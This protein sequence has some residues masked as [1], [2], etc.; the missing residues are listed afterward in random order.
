MATTVKF[1]NK[2]K[3]QILKSCEKLSIQA[4]AGETYEVLPEHS[5]SKG[6]IKKRVRGND[7]IIENTEEKSTVELLNY[8]NNCTN[9]G[10][11]VI[12]DSSETGLA[13][14]SSGLSWG[15]IGLIAL[16]V[17]AAGAAAAGGGG[18]GGGGSTSSTSVADTTA[19][20]IAVRVNTS[21]LAANGTATVTF[22][23][24]EASN[25]FTLADVTAT[26]GVL[27]NFSG[28][29]TAYTA[30]FTANSGVSAA[31]VSVASGTFSDAAGNVNTDGADANNTVTFTVASVDTT[32]PSV[33]VVAGNTNL[34]VGSTV[35]LTFTLSEASTNFTASDVNVVGGV[36]S[37]FSGSGTHYTATFTPTTGVSS[38]SVSVLSGVFSDAIGNVNNDGADANNTVSFTV[39]SA[40]APQITNT[41]IDF[42]QLETQVNATNV[43]FQA[44]GTNVASWALEGSDAGLFSVDPSGNVRFNGTANFEAPSDL[45]KD[46]VYHLTLKAID[47]TGT[48]AD[49]QDFTIHLADVSEI[50]T[51]LNNAAYGTS[52]VGVQSL[53]NADGEASSWNANG[54][55]SAIAN[56][57]ISLTYSFQGVG[58]LFEDDFGGLSAID[59][60]F[61]SAGK[62]FIRTVFANF[63]SVANIAY[64]ENS[65]QV[66]YGAD[67]R[68]FAGTYA[69]LNSDANTL[70][71]AYQPFGPTVT[72]SDYEGNFFF[73]T[74]SSGVNGLINT[75]FSTPYGDEKNT[76][77]H[78]LGHA[79]GLDHPF[80]D[81]N[82]GAGF[83]DY[84][85]TTDTYTNHSGAVTGGGHDTPLTDTTLETIMT[86]HNPDH[87]PASNVSSGIY[88]QTNTP[89]QLGIYDI[90]A[91]QNLYGVNYTTNAGDTQ[92]TFN[93]NT[94]SYLT[95]WDGGG[96]D[97]ITHI[98]DNSALINLNEGTRSHVGTTPGWMLHDTGWTRTITA[99]N[100]TTQS[101]GTATIDA[102]G[103]G[104]VFTANMAAGGYNGTYELTLTFSDNSTQVVNYGVIADAVTQ[105]SQYNL[106][107]AFGVTVENAVGG[108]GDDTIIGNIASNHIT[109]GAGN[110]TMTGGAAG[111]WFLFDDI[112][113]TDTITDFTHGQDVL[114]FSSAMAGAISFSAGVLTV[115]GFGS[116]NLTGIT[117]MVVGT[118]YVF[119]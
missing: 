24:S 10:C 9:S 88:T 84:Y 1:K 61:T 55:S 41:V 63:S 108:N 87:G 30:I 33:A 34:G 89:W 49:T 12:I 3:T 103:H 35:T 77:S 99:V 37:N 101:N 5:K 38:A 8:V 18:G 114:Q 94:P 58:A 81:A 29:G 44:V 91:L 39:S 21:S 83:S 104:Y 98:G 27:S 105:E 93:Q 45:N 116:I 82:S 19:P 17:G 69:R 6:V 52:N 7:L 48:A 51:W 57:P 71:F 66:L 16:G 22:T 92:Y 42:T 31:H 65:S 110:D 75:P 73:I 43:V 26:G 64:T 20:T 28:S 47:P 13:S 102:D 74:N 72:G 90:A 109:G 95:I 70:G 4:Q 112:F 53:L 86:Y 97:T 23:L 54:T 79:M 60:A 36:L 56:T 76:I 32:P 15:T 107:I 2:G 106:G 78:E 62:D 100:V 111:D 113:G 119:A 59:G 80:N 85:N 14:S 46:A 115:A 40:L 96:N 50:P 117:D 68:L 25:N 67:I 11:Q 118:D